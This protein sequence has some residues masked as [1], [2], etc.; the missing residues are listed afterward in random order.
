[1][2]LHC[3]DLNLLRFSHMWQGSSSSMPLTKVT[4]LFSSHFLPCFG[5]SAYLSAPLTYDLLEDAGSILFVHFQPDTQKFAINICV[6]LSGK[7]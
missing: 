3:Y 5:L 7:N 4:E 1:M 6:V 2:L